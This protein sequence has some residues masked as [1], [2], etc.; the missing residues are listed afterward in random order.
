MGAGM[1]AVVFQP[2]SSSYAKDP[3]LIWL[4][5]D[6]CE[7]IPAFS[8]QRAGAKFTLLFSHANAEDLGLI[9][10]SFK[11]L[12]QV[13]HVNVFSYEYTGY[14]MSTGQTTEAAVY[15]DIE[16]A[17]RYVRDIIGVPWE[18]IVLYGRSIGTGPSVHLAS[19]TAVRGLVL[20]SPMLSIFRIPFQFR[21]TL[22][23][24]MFTNVDKIAHVCCPVFIIHGTRDEIVPALHGIQLYEACQKRGI[25]HQPFWVKDADHNNLEM[26]AG[27]SFS[28]HFQGFLEHLETSPISPKLRA[29]EQSLAVG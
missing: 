2:P 8:L 21:Y 18:Q 17:F 5:T 27:D 19:R 3:N 12:S 13:L 11:E 26:Q 25:A 15:S 4:R 24:D 22:P 20:Q 10:R 6:R 1:S 7:V 23:G 29:Q 14:G 9:I 16:A 28:S